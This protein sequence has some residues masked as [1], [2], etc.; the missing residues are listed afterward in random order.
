MLPDGV[1][2]FNLLNYALGLTKI[3]FSDYAIASVGML[4][5]TLLYVY[6][7]RLI[8]DVAAITSGT[9]TERGIEE[10]ALLGLGAL[11]TLM[12]VVLVTRTARRALDR[13]NALVSPSPNATPPKSPA[14]SPASTRNLE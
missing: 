13:S 12:V 5:G 1:F 11:A 7:G 3:R 14:P 2:P 10:Y 9:R 8:G 6:T 4:P